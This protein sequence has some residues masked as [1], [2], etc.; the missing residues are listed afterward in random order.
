MYQPIDFVGSMEALCSEREQ[1]SSL[2]NQ[3]W[4]Q[5]ASKTSSLLFLKKTNGS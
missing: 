5:K 4:S 1:D 3:Q 2:G